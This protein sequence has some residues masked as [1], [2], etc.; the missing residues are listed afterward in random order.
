MPSTAVSYLE[1]VEMLTLVPLGKH[2][3][4]LEPPVSLV[5][6]CHWIKHDEGSLVADVTSWLKGSCL[7]GTVVLLGSSPALASYVLQ[8]TSPTRQTHLFETSHTQGVSLSD[9]PMYHTGMGQEK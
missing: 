2:Y 5:E 6:R 1:A 3:A 4:W 7:H 8:L 9:S